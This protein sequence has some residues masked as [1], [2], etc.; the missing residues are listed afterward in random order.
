LQA[1]ADERVAR[2][3]LAGE[4]REA[5]WDI[6]AIQAEAAQADV[7]VRSLKQLSEDVARRVRAG[8]LARADALAAQAE[9]LAATA[10]QTDARQRLQAAAARWTVLTGL[11]ASPDPGSTARIDA[12]AIPVEASA[13]HPELQLAD[14]SVDLARKRVALMRLSRREAPELT[15]GLRQDTGGRGESTQGSLV[16]ELKLPFARRVTERLAGGAE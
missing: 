3:R 1:L 13:Q 2:L 7:E 10:Q 8:D 5:A 16:V 9:H 14:Q 6:A 15:V 11:T 12:A 4:L